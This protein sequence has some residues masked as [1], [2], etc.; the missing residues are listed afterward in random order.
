MMEKGRR[1]RKREEEKG[2]EEKHSNGLTLSF[3]DDYKKQLLHRKDS[4]GRNLFNN[5]DKYANRPFRL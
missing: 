2:G 4:F 1:R 3:Y 5:P